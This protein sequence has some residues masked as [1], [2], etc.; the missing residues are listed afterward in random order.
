MTL[1]LGD[2]INMEGNGEVKAVG[3]L[4]PLTS[5]PSESYLEVV[6]NF[7]RWGDTL[8][9]L[10]TCLCKIAPSDL[11]GLKRDVE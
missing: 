1:T 3:L 5:L 7:N 4:L 6:E 9:M 2:K 11:P 8:D 10:S